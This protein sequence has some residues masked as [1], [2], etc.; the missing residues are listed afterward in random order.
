MHTLLKTHLPNQSF[1]SLFFQME[2]NK[3]VD[4]S[5]IKEHN[6]KYFE[7]LQSGIEPPTPMGIGVNESILPT[8][9][10]IKVET[11]TEIN[12]WMVDNASDFLNYCCPECDFKDKN[13]HLFSD[14]ALENHKKA[15]VLFDEVSIDI[16]ENQIEE[17]EYVDYK[18]DSKNIF[19]GDQSDISEDISETNNHNA[20]E[21]HENYDLKSE[22]SDFIE[23]SVTNSVSNDGE[24][25]LDKDQPIFSKCSLCDFQ[26][27]YSLRNKKMQNHLMNVHGDS[28]GRSIFKCQKCGKE[29]TELRG[30][31]K[32]MKANCLDKRKK[33]KKQK[34]TKVENI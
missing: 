18:S 26:I 28:N 20:S 1:I 4:P 3:I 29:L 14:H 19:K 30:M 32:H 12:P 5:K 8:I 34:Q 13:L 6:D 25:Y 33:E 9:D 10:P 21:L 31:K 11:I 16:K 24:K 2:A 7:S 27:E 17:N 23:T 22:P 15:S